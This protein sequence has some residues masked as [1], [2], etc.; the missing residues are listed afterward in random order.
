G[1]DVVGVPDEGDLLDQ[2]DNCGCQAEEP[3]DEKQYPESTPRSRSWRAIADE[4]TFGR[5]SQGLHRM[6]SSRSA[7]L[8][9]SRSWPLRKNVGVLCTPRTCPSCW[10]CSMRARVAGSR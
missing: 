3:A 8:V 5:L 10:L 1:R 9:G 2:Q 4:T 6:P 7:K